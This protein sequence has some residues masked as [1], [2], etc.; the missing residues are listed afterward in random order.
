[1]SRKMKFSISALIMYLVLCVPYVVDEISK[2]TE[3][4]QAFLRF[5]GI[6]LIA[7]ALWL[8]ISIL[9]AWVKK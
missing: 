8:L 2:G 7:V 9:G 1:M 6:I 4:V 3:F 5:N